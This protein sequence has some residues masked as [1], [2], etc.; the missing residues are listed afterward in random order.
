MYRTLY[1]FHTFF[2]SIVQ[3]LYQSVVINK[4]K[5]ARDKRVEFCEVSLLLRINYSSRYLSAR[6]EGGGGECLMKN[7]QCTCDIP[8][9]NSAGSNKS[10]FRYRMQLVSIMLHSDCVL[11]VICIN[12]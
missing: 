3:F 9:I 2:R 8:N 5:N 1:S 10:R 11:H 7:E 6:E 12:N 4:N